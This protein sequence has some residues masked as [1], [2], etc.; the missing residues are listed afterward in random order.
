MLD[1]RNVCT[2]ANRFSFFSLS[3]GEA[4]HCRRF[5]CPP[6]RTEHFGGPNETR[7]TRQR[8]N[9]SAAE[10]HAVPNQRK[11]PKPARRTRRGYGG[12]T[13]GQ[14]N[15]TPK[16]LEKQTAP[17]F[18]RPQLRSDE[19]PRRQAANQPRSPARHKRRTNSQSNSEPTKPRI[20]HHTS[21]RRGQPEPGRISAPPDRESGGR[22]IRRRGAGEGANG[23]RCRGRREWPRF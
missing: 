1:Y 19:A 11:N 16:V 17:A 14:F 21:E 6:R 10:S 22:R 2:D 12:F 9:H 4:M 15:Q 13:L 8:W 20:T 3:K 5:D 18:P 23:R 7:T